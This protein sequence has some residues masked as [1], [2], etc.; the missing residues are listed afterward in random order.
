VRV[1]TARKQLIGTGRL[2]LARDDR[3]GNALQA[4]LPILGRIKHGH[5]REIARH[6]PGGRMISGNRRSWNCSLVIACSTSRLTRSDVLDAGETKTIMPSHRFRARLT[7][8][9][10][11][12]PGGTSP[13]HHTTPIGWPEMGQVDEALRELVASWHSLTPAVRAAIIDLIR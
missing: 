10:Q 3:L 4:P 13:S 11:S 6:V 5:Q 9:S 1:L 12:F 7:W 2:P 8:R